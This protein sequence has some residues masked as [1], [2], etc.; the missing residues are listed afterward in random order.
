MAEVSPSILA[1]DLSNLESEVKSLEGHIDYVHL[2]VMDGH[3]VPNLTFGFPIAEAL[4]RITGVP[5]DIH[6]MVTNPMD[7]LERFLKLQPAIVAVHYEVCTNLYM[8]LKIIR[9]GGSKAFVAL[10]PQ[11]P[12]TTLEDILP[13]LDGVLIM[14]VNPGFSGQEF[15]PS[16]MKKIEKL[17]KMADELNPDLKIAVDGG[18]NPENAPDL[19]RSGANILVM[20]SAVFRSDDPVRVCE[21]VRSL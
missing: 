3:F 9:D 21:E 12:V 10:N 19:V 16:S 20:G 4:K 18:V 17:R 5:L 2:D 6:L 14:S 1:A 11:T 8:A 13:Y 15:I 7:L